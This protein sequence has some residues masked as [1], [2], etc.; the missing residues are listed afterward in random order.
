MPLGV[1]RGP[2][3]RARHFDPHGAET[4]MELERHGRFDPRRSIPATSVTLLENNRRERTGSRDRGSA[5]GERV[6]RPVGIL[7]LDRE[8]GQNGLIPDA[9]SRNAARAAARHD[10]LCDSGIDRESRRLTE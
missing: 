8:I 6:G 10:E 4:G 2:R 5:N 1:M 9:C 7:R 3:I